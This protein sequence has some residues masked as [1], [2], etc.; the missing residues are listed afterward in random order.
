MA[1]IPYPEMDQLDPEVRGPI[2]AFSKEHGR[3]TL[4]RWMLA[5]FPPALKGIDTL[6][7]PMMTSGKLPRQLKELIFV[8]ASNERGCHY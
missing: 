6:Y 1:L 8:A 4:V 7:H 2:E 3:P 5:W